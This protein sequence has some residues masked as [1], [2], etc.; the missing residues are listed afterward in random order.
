M[1]PLAVGPLRRMK[2]AGASFDLPERPL[3]PSPFEFDE[4]DARFSIE[5]SDENGIRVRLVR[6]VGPLQVVR[7]E[8]AIVLDHQ[9]LSRSS[10]GD[11]DLD[12]ATPRRWLYL[13]R[14]ERMH[15]F[16]FVRTVPILFNSSARSSFTQP[17]SRS[18]MKA[19]S[20][21]TS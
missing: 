2:V 20:R 21:S 7:R 17:S 4:E 8:I 11:P 12:E 19:L 1:V 13:E 14:R 18:S 16:V 6:P 10:V 15:Q 3:V 9:R 5:L